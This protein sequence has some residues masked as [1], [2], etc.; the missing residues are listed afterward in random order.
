MHFLQTTAA[1]HPPLRH[2]IG[3]LRIFCAPLRKSACLLQR[4]EYGSIFSDEAQKGMTHLGRGGFGLALRVAHGCYMPTVPIK[5]S[6]KAEI[7][8]VDT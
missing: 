7:V 8:H 3:F 1:V 5:I 2:G 4:P 6:A